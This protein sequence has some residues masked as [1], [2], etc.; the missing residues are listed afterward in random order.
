[1]E[2]GE[3]RDPEDERLWA[4]RLTSGTAPEPRFVLLIVAAWILTPLLW[5]ARSLRWLVSVPI[6][7]HT[8]RRPRR[9]GDGGDHG[10]ELRR[11]LAELPDPVR[12]DVHNILAAVVADQHGRWQL[13]GVFR[14]RSYVLSSVDG[15]RVVRRMPV[16]DREPEF[17]RDERGWRAETVRG[18]Y[19]QDAG[20]VA[21][22]V[23][24]AHVSGG[25]SLP[26]PWQI[27][28]ALIVTISHRDHPFALSERLE[29]RTHGFVLRRA[30]VSADVRALLRGHTR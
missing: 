8:M 6:R 16:K 29:C 9:S 7:L 18:W 19:R 27:E 13:G 12:E 23:A 15:R 1:M 21:G 5:V 26:A 10:V 25:Y 28:D 24:T 3:G 14:T 4:D 11:R 20:R 30:A 22:H 2:T 17:F